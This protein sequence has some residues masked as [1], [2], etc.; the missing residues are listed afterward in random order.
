MA[1]DDAPAKVASAVR[2]TAIVAARRRLLAADTRSPLLVRRPTAAGID[3]AAP[4]AAD[5]AARW[6]AT[7]AVSR[8]RHKDG[9][10]YVDLL[11]AEPRAA[12]GS[13][14][15]DADVVPERVGR[16]GDERRGPERAGE[17]TERGRAD[18]H[19]A[20]GSMHLHGEALP[21]GVEQR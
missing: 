18:R 6:H 7:A 5:T 10:A 13:P 1:G 15:A 14:S 11:T 17:V 3:S 20:G 9:A 4:S 8:F 16:A 12:G 19:R 21:D 2:P